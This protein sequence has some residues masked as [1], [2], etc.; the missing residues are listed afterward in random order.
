MM[1]GKKVLRYSFVFIMLCASLAVTFASIHVSRA[2]S[3]ITATD[4]Q[5]PSGLDP[6]GTTLDNNGNVW[7]AVPGCNPNPD[8]GS[9]TSPGKI[10]VFSSTSFSWTAIY[11]LPSGYGQALFLAFDGSGNLWFPMFHTNTLGEMLASDHSFHQWPM[12]TAASGPWDLAFDHNGKLWI[13]EH[14]INKIAEFDPS[15]DKFINEVSTPATNSEPYGITVDSSNNI[16]FTENNSS[17]ALIGEYTAGGQLQEYKIRT[18]S[19][20]NLTPHLISVASNGNIWWTEGFAGMIGELNTTGNIV[21]EY[22]YPQLCKGCGTH[23]SGIG[24]DSNGLI[25]FDDSL[26]NTFGSYAT[27]TGTFSMYTAPSSRS[28]PHDGLQVDGQ[29]RVW[30]DEQ[31]AEKLAV[32]VQ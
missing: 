27:G 5:I 22:S 13:T 1:W 16:W 28:H 26:Q 29:N 7:V 18:G 12:P 9:R 23:A 8:C 17:V 32:A 6:W 25:W 21:S 20:T 30:F 11:N 31:Y 10:E 3:S 15:I 24:I 14:F 2:A 19:T 4:Y